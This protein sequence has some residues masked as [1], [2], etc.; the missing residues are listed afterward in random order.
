[1][2][3]VS[4]L[5]LG[6]KV[7]RSGEEAQRGGSRSGVLVEEQPANKSIKSMIYFMQQ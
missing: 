4:L 6:A 3:G 7:V 1:M 2:G 5:G